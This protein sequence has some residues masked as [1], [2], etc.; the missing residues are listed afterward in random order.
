[1]WMIFSTFMIVTMILVIM[2]LSY[3]LKEIPI[4]CFALLIYS[5]FLLTFLF[6]LL[7]ILTFCIGFPCR[8]RLAMRSS[9]G[10]AI[11][12]TKA[13]IADAAARRGKGNGARGSRR[14]RGAATSPRGGRGT[15]T[16]PRG[17]RGATIAS[18]GGRGPRRLEFVSEEAHENDGVEND[19]E[20][21]GEEEH[22]D[23]R[24]EEHDG[25]RI[26]EEAEVQLEADGEEEDGD[27][28]IVYLRGPAG[29]PPLPAT[30]H[31]KLV[32]KPT[33]DL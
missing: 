23:D 29:L 18:R 8:K 33:G 32:I 22:E 16:A 24:E 17:G 6:A 2:I 10:R 12:P 19:D 30:D 7:L 26:E 5:I 4:V 14:G 15:T 13:A 25:E 31:E 11:K 3:Q 20:Y 9:R 21:D 27:Q 1:M 28:A